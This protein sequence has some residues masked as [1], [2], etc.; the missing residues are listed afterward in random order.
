MA[1]YNKNDMQGTDTKAIEGCK[2]KP[3]SSSLEKKKKAKGDLTKNMTALPSENLVSA[4]AASVKA[5]LG[6]NCLFS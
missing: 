6:V 5:A 2:T 4:S 1:W 3:I